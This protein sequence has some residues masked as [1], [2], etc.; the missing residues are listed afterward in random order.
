MFCRS[1]SSSTA[2]F[3]I[4]SQLLFREDNRLAYRVSST[5]KHSPE[6]CV[7]VLAELPEHLIPTSFEALLILGFPED[8]LDWCKLIMADL[9]LAQGEGAVVKQI[10]L[11]LAQ[12]RFGGEEW[13]LEQVDWSD[14]STQA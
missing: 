4:P 10:L 6:Q 3:S 9:L 13:T 5:Y 7:E 14:L 2:D 11:R 12:G 8:V 1:V